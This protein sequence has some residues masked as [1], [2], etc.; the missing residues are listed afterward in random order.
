MSEWE[1]GVRVATGFGSPWGGRTWW[2]GCEVDAKARGESVAQG[3][4]VTTRTG[5]DGEAVTRDGNDGCSGIP[6]SARMPKHISDDRNGV[7]S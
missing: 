5:N 4:A 7:G 6:T 2:G 1:V 3:D